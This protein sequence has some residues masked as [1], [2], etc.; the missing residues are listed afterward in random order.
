M[1]LIYFDVFDLFVPSEVHHTVIYDIP[2]E[3]KILRLVSLQE[4]IKC[5]YQDGWLNAH[6]VDDFFQ[7]GAVSRSPWPWLWAQPAV[8]WI[9]IVQYAITNNFFNVG[10]VCHENITYGV[11]LDYYWFFMQVNL[12]WLQKFCIPPDLHQVP[13]LPREEGTFICHDSI[14]DIQSSI[15]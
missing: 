2:L 10:S 5:L 11:C 7:D 14:K 3:D 9:V 4:C 1:P 12:L 15:M 13:I 8:L 6:I